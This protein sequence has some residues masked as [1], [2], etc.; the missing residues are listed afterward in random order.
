MNLSQLVSDDE[1]SQVDL[2]C[3]MGSQA[4]K[5]SGITELKD[6]CSSSDQVEEKTPPKY[7]FQPAGKSLKTY[8]V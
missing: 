1:Q 8:F 4:K 2:F 5:K 7:F 6:I 3:V